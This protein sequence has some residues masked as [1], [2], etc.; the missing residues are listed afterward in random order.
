[1]SGVRR[2]LR[3]QLCRVLLLLGGGTYP[4]LL[5]VF[6]PAFVLFPFESRRSIR[7]RTAALQNQKLER[8]V[9]VCSAAPHYPCFVRKTCPEVVVPLH[10][11]LCCA[12]SNADAGADVCGTAALAP[13]H[14]VP[15]SLA[16][17]VR[18]PTPL[19]DFH[20]AESIWECVFV[21]LLMWLQSSFLF[22]LCVFG[23]V[24]S[25]VGG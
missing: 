3:L 10:C 25:F 14:K 16:C 24:C 6:I 9:P 13:P 17:A 5:A 23:S 12:G 21:I 19:F 18:T 15:L 7:A 20:A 1:M 8:S 11:C 2:A 4:T 22:C